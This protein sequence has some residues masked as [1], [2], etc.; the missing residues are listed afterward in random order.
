MFLN[1]RSFSQSLLLTG[2]HLLCELSVTCNAVWEWLE[3]VDD[4][5]TVPLPYTS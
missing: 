5:K 1:V 4:R 2:K 3:M